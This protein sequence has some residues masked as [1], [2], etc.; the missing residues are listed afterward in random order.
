[1]L[2]VRERFDARSVIATTPPFSLRLSW[3]ARRGFPVHAERHVATIT[4]ASVKEG[5]P[6]PRGARWD[7]KGTNFALFSANATKVEVCLF[8]ATGK[9]EEARIEL[10]EYTDQVF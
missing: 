1:M 2:R 8:D 4:Q 6:H 7:G 10:P 5:L 3:R 9:V